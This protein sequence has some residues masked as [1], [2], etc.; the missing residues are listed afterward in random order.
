M[1]I[2]RSVALCGGHESVGVINHRTQR[3]SSGREGLSGGGER[4][5]EERGEEGFASVASIGVSPSL[6]TSSFC[7]YKRNASSRCKE[8]GVETLF[9]YLRC[10][11]LHFVSGKR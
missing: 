3:R 8:A 1:E 4:A 5:K 11:R 6:P 7:I 9:L 2:S 10:S